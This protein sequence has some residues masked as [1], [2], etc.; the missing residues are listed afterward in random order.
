MNAD[1]TAENKPAYSP[2]NKRFTRRSE[3]IQKNTHEYQRAIQVFVA[4][5]DKVAVMVI[6]HL[7]ELIVELYGG[8]VGRP[9]ES[10]KES[11]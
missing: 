11:W 9:Q 3:C 5:F 4:F 6:G 1:V 7:M 10:R 2:T 8:V